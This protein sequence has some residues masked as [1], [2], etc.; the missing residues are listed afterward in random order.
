MKRKTLLLLAMTLV[1]AAV[2]AQQAKK[3]EGYAITAPE[4]GSSGW[5]EVRLMDIVSGQE[6][7]TIYKGSQE[8]DLLNART[9]NPITKKD[10]T[11]NPMVPNPTKR[12]VNL[13][14]E[15]DR[16]QPSRVQVYSYT[17]S[18][19][20]DQHAKIERDQLAAK[21]KEVTGKEIDKNID[22]QVE[23]Q[24]MEK[25]M[26]YVMVS[27]YNSIKV[28]SD[29]P[30]ATNS[31]A[32][33]YDKKHDRL[34]YT[35][36]S[37]AQL[38]YI[39]LKAKKPT[40]YYFEDEP[41]GTVSGPGDAP[42]QI[43]RMVF[44]SDGNGYA[45]TNSGDHLIRFTTGKKPEIT[46][47]G[48][49]TDAEA[50][51]KYSV[52]SRGGYGGDMIADAQGNLYLVQA[53]HN[54][55]KFNIDQKVASYLGTIQGLPRGFTTN[56]A[57]VEEAGKVII[58]SSESTVGYYRFDL[59]NM[60]AP[61]ELVSQPG[62][63]FNASDLAN[64]NLAFDKKK[65][66]KKN[67]DIKEETKDVV[68]TDASR[69]PVQE[70]PAGGTITVY[71]NPVTDGFVRLQFDNQPNGKYQ[72]QLLD[73]GGKLINS[74]EVNINNKLQLEQFRIPQSVSKGNYLIKVFSEPNN[75]SVTTK[76][77]VQ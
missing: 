3:I 51:G 76:I 31:A 41:F 65:K 67:N 42:N 60:Q 37:I 75:V 18:D 43:T 2:Q 23:K 26:T 25:Q 46:D 9:G 71:P 24:M 66:D 10:I 44:A 27:G 64:G 47:L 8:V 56:G 32:M 73:M 40:I 16:N 36:M 53:N 14:M 35:P 1:I 72:V 38:R 54:V 49:L 68:V 33:A 58:A 77:L 30:F 22:K 13:D 50:N 63:V 6:V 70:N 59:A 5:K 15:M 20:N 48:A 4:K 57:M 45:L 7:Q 29:K 62:E 39:D 11:L 52:H 61:A 21:V 17:P 55:F 19:P 34:Y 28:S 74:T 69:D 12:V